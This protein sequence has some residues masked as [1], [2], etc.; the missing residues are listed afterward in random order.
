MQRT[1]EELLQ[2]LEQELL[3]LGYVEGTMS[4][5]QGRWR[6]LLKFAEERGAI[7]FS[8]QLGLD[9]LKTHFHI[10]RKDLDN[11][12]SQRDVQD[13]RVVRMI[14]DF[15]LHHVVLRRYYKHHVL[16][17]DPYYVVVSANFKRH[18][19]HKGYSPV[20]VDHYVKLSARFMD[21][22]L[23]QGIHDCSQIT[24]PLVNGYIRTLA[25][26]TYKTV[27]Q[28]ICAI[29]AFL[30]Y[31]NDNGILNEDL[32]SKTPMVQARKQT[33]IPSVWTKEEL[34]ALIEA[35]DRGSPK[36]KRDYAIILLACVLGLRV[37]D[38][39]QL[40]F[41]NFN[42]EE[43]K[44]TF[45]QSKTHDTV[46]LPIPQEVG[47][48]VIDYLQ[49]GRPKVN[50]PV[51][52][53]RHMAP[54]LPFAEGDHLSQLIKSYMQIAHLPTLKKHRGMH[55][56]R[57]TAASRML[58]HDT[59]LEVISDILGHSDTNSTAVYLK[60]DISKLKECALDTPEVTPYA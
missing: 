19:E 57:H 2:D 28:N 40:T 50:F 7:Y 21:Y 32:A 47:W 58:E 24:L 14:G 37:S 35:I 26:Y 27:E 45:T 11:T 53:V 1:L 16:L 56:L 17:T 15:Q 30:R 20:T 60:V 10:L 12:L 4:F 34:K 48:A 41:S 29:R 51:I 39:K 8:E 23:A 36:G 33:Q 6:K 42:W 49:Y 25:G 44:L 43:K 52:F 46:T 38:I 13:I 54:F 55:S 22:L 59:P 9:F 5:Y 31:L 3:R 18:C